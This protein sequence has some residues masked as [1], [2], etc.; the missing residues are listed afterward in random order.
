MMVCK[1]YACHVVMIYNTIASGFNRLAKVPSCDPVHDAAWAA[2]LLGLLVA[3]E[4]NSERKAVRLTE[5]LT[6]AY[7]TTA[8][9]SC[10]VSHQQPSWHARITQPYDPPSSLSGS[11]NHNY[12]SNLPIAL[13]RAGICLVLT[14]NSALDLAALNQ[15]N[16]LFFDLFDGPSECSAHSVEANGLE[17][18]E[19]K[20]H[21]DI[22]NEVCQ[23]IYMWVQ[24]NVHIVARLTQKKTDQRYEPWNI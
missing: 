15:R 14:I 19:I 18:L 17:R 20:H 16:Y 11:V 24:V 10:F 4:L 8:C 9:G 1:Q 6:D 13:S 5:A 7:A 12:I 22:A 21:C 23:V 2:S 3:C